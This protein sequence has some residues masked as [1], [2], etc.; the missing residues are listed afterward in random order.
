MKLQTLASLLLL[1]SVAAY[2]TYHC[3]AKQV[4]DC[5]TGGAYGCSYVEDVK[6]CLVKAPEDDKACYNACVKILKMGNY[7]VQGG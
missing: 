5:K 2:K 4:S 7:R 1:Q 6:T 3:S